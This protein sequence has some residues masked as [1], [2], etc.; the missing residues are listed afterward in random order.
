M[1][2]S[3][4]GWQWQM[5]AAGAVLTALLAYRVSASREPELVAPS[6]AWSPAA[7]VAVVAGDEVWVVP[8]LG[9]TPRRVYAAPDGEEII[10]ATAD[11]DEGV[12]FVHVVHE[13]GTTITAQALGADRREIVMSW[14]KRVDRVDL[15]VAGRAAARVLPR[16]EPDTRGR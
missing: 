3:I 9:G 14:A 2:A 11:A 15:S 10:G 16:R 13:A 8:R 1:R 6:P 7:L 12:V 4:P 5:V